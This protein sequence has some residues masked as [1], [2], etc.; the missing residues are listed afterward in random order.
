MGRGAGKFI[1]NYNL[2]LIIVID[3]FPNAN[4]LIRNA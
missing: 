4:L 2:Q 1:T 3:P